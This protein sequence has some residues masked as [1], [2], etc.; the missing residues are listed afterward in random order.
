MALS[1]FP[2]SASLTA[3]ALAY[4][5]TGYIADAVLPR[6]IVGKQAF[7]W[8]EIPFDTFFNPQDTLVGR[9]GQVN[10]VDL[11]GREFTDSTEDHGLDDAVP[12]SDID[13]ADERYD[14]LGIAT[15]GLT[16]FVALRREIRAAAL[17]QNP[18]SFDPANV[19]A[20]AGGSQF[21]DYNNSDPIGVVSSAL[22]KC[23]M[24]PNQLVFSQEG[25]TKFR[26]HPKI[27]SAVNASGAQ[28]GM[29]SRQAVADLFEVS[30]VLVGQ[31]R[32]NSAKPGQAPAL[33][34]VW[35]KHI[36]ALYKAPVP[37]MKGSVT[38]GATFQWGDKVAGDW[39][40]K[41]IGLR[42]GKWVRV[43]ESVKERILA[44]QCGALIQNAFA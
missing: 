18:A 9:K 6:I 29:A 22:D 3:I 39:E 11:G 25:W 20:L 15:M 16:E 32:V 13:N 34:R 26:G 19:Q 30:E 4:K 21:S 1:P 41:K 10:Q 8:M 40:D 31:S 28:S 35:G 17:V 2:I 36:A 14:P 33:S 7:T 23:L 38:F 42:G 37:E 5:N 12:Q 27:I 24:R 44:G 43:G